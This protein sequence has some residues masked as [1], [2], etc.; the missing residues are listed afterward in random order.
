MLTYH[1][2]RINL[3]LW[4]LN[5]LTSKSLLMGLEGRLSSY[6]H[7]FLQKAWVILTSTSSRKHIHWNNP[8]NSKSLIEF[9]PILLNS[10][11][12]PLVWLMLQSKLPPGSSRCSLPGALPLGCRP[13]PKSNCCKI[14]YTGR[15][16][17][18]VSYM[19]SGSLLTGI[20]KRRGFGFVKSSLN[21]LFTLLSIPPT[22]VR[23]ALINWGN[24]CPLCGFWSKGSRC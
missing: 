24:K 13:T 4:F 23:G 21:G 8:K 10:S 2:S 22:Q 18:E 9:P 15:T 6:E 16:W 5:F 17:L 1:Y 11:G 14:P 20:H 19:E 12:K 7:L 3:L